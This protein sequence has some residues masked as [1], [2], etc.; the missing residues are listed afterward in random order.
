MWTKSKSRGSV[1]EQGRVDRWSSKGEAGH[2]LSSGGRRRGVGFGSGRRT[3]AS[4]EPAAILYGGRE[5]ESVERLG[6]SGISS[7]CTSSRFI[8]RRR[9]EGRRRER[10]NSRCLQRH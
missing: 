2:D 5:G 1:R 6:R 10:E 9:R 3:V 4:R 8:E 7:M